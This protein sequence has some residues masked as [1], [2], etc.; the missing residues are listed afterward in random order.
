MAQ[1]LSQ[2]YLKETGDS[3][4]IVRVGLNGYK[5]YTKANSFDGKRRLIWSF[6]VLDGD[7]GRLYDLWS[8]HQTM[9]LQTI[10]G[11]QI[12]VRVVLYPTDSDSFGLLEFLT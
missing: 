8:H 9:L 10:K 11:S 5:S 7:Q 2:A 4:P 1:E 12:A 6:T 3:R